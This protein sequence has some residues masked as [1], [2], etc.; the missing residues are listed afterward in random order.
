MTKQKKVKVEVVSGVE[1]PCLVI[2]DTRVAGPKPWGGGAVIME[3]E[4]E[5]KELREAIKEAKSV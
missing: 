4:I 2:G 3:W 1:G 5:A